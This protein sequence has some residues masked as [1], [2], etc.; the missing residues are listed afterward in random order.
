M[1]RGSLSTPVAA[2]KTV[3]CILSALPAPDVRQGGARADQRIERDGLIVE[4]QPTRGRYG[5]QDVTVVFAKADLPSR[6]ALDW[7]VEKIA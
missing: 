7:A 3:R 4:L 5:Y 1:A 6:P 2:G